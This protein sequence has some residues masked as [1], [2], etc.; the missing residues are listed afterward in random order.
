MAEELSGGAEAGSSG[1]A[2]FIAAVA[3]HA[4]LSG[5]RAAALVA[6]SAVLDG[7]G[8]LLLVPLLQIITGDGEGWIGRSAATLLAQAGITGRQSMLW[9]LL[10]AFLA[11]AGLRALANNRRDVAL[12]KLQTGFAEAERNRL[13]AALAGAPWPRLVQLRHADTAALL[14][15]EGQRLASACS[16]LIQGS[17]QIVLLAAQTVV[18]LILAP[19]LTAA[20]L[21][22]LTVG[23]LALAA[24]RQRTRGLGEGVVKASQAMMASASA[25]LAGLKSA[26]AQNAQHAFVAEF[27][28]TQASLRDH[29]LDFAGRQARGRMTYSIVSAALAAAVVG[30]GFGLLGLPAP[31]L[32]TLVLV[33]A[34]M[35]APAQQL[36]QNAQALMFAVPAFEAVRRTERALLPAA[37]PAGEAPVPP[38]GGPIELT[39]VTYR[40]DGGGG[41][42]EVDLLVQPGSFVGIGGPSGGGKTTLADLIAGLLE[43]QT[44]TI[45]VGGVLIRGPVRMGWGECIAYVTQEGF[46]F[47]D[48]LRRNLLWGAAGAEE[49]EIGAVLALVG[50]DKLIAGLERG[51]ETMIG[52]RG[53]ALSGG[54]RQRLMIARALLRRPRLLL[55]DE[56]LSAL[57]ADSE[58]LLLNRLKALEPRPA[59]LMISHREKS[60]EQCDL[61]VR[62]ENGGVRVER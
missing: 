9:A 48:T 14:L 11:L 41:V 32:L 43:P 23:T 7:A 40:H 10:A 8:L 59:I 6:A 26:V 53:G 18:G 58:A 31:I 2:A 25:L 60:L 44:G 17:V 19:A 54:E 28:A 61:I 45:T 30:I 15:S 42:S 39:G 37:A 22:M 20:A 36:Y 12:A 1:L 13:I 33:F 24:G 56:A 21:A 5:L 55:L 57:D 16:Y 38:P 29:Q 49:A 51:L 47:H 50:A 52:E 46:L 27:E 4:G 34:R 3:R 35:G 62:V